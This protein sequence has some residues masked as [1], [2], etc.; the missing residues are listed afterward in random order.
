[1]V[2]QN[3]FLKNQASIPMINELT[4]IPVLLNEI[5]DYINR[6]QI[7]NGIIVDATFGLG[8]YSKTFLEKTNCNVFAFDRDPKVKKYAQLLKNKYQTR[9]QFYNTNFSQIENT[10]QYIDDKVNAIVFDLG[11]S[12]LQLGDPERGFSFKLNGPL[13]MRMSNK[14]IDAYDVINNYKSEEIANILFSLGDEFY[15]KKIA[16]EIIKARKINPISTTTTLAELI[17]KAIP[18][19]NKRIDKATKSFQAIRMFVNDEISELKKGLIQSE[20]ILNFGG[21]LAVVSFH[22]KEDKI[23]KNFL[24]KCEGKTE[25]YS[26]KFFPPN[27]KYNSSFEILTKKPVKPSKNEVY[28]NP[29]S[30]S[31]K[32]RVARRTKFSPIHDDNGLAA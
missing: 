10:T 19:R 16:R 24:K 28:L 17:R 29:K 15:S 4:H 8:S 3:L 9:F 22:S 6:L 14:G 23:V 1:M 30:R 32:L 12:N 27:L 31:A 13:D 18:G 26:S 7:D 20:K 25:F 21:L 11:V 2:L 5:L